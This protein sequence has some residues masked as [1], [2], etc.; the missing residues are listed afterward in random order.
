[1]MLSTEMGLWVPRRCLL[2]E[3]APKES[4]QFLYKEQNSG[5]LFEA[6][7]T[8]ARNSLRCVQLEDIG[9]GGIAGVGS[10]EL[11]VKDARRSSSR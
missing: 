9:S 10:L 2:N 7:I 4:H 6:R 1:M 11:G 3:N 8:K 5:M